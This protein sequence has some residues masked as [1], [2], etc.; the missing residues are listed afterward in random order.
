MRNAPLIISVSHIERITGKSAKTCRRKLKTI[1]K[2]L[3]KLPHHDVT[4][5]EFCK[6]RGI[7]IE[8][9]CKTLNYRPPF[10]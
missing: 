6:H 4:V 9:F 5:P 3:H 10:D 2:D 7:S 1:K 8:E